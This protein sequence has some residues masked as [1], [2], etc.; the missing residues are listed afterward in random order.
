MY[1]NTE[2]FGI[3]MWPIGIIVLFLFLFVL[4]K[5]KRNFYFLLFF[6][7]FWVYIM[8]GF[9]KVFFPID[10]SGPFVDQMRLHTPI[11]ARVNIVPFH[12]GQYGFT[13]QGLISG[14]YNIVLTIPFGFGLNFISRVKSKDFLIISLFLGV[15]IE[16]IQLSISLLLRYPYRVVDINDS[17]SNALGALIGYGL[18]RLF[19]W[20]YL[21]ISQKLTL[22][23]GGLSLYIYDIVNNAQSKK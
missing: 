21:W 22:E 16:L 12:F 19:A 20:I 17:M 23:H 9:D 13:M 4:W 11:M 14:L 10:I 2:N 18:F 3:P 5:R 6:S 15:G 1:I 8:Y 7:I